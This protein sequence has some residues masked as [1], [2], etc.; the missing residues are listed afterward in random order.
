ML[1]TQNQLSAVYTG[2]RAVYQEG[3]LLT[4]SG[5]EDDWKQI[6]L[7]AP[8]D[9]EQEEYGFMKNMSTI[10]EWVGDRHLQSMVEGSYFIK[11]KPFEGTIAVPATKIADR[12]LGGFSIATKQLGQNARVFPNRLVFPLLAAGF[13]NRGFDGQYFF[14]ANHPV[15]RPDG[16]TDL[17]SNN[18]GGSGAP[19]FLLDTTKIIKPIVFQNRQAFDFVSLTDMSRSDHV[20]MRN[21]YLFGTDGRCN[22][23]YGLWQTAYGSKQALT[24]DNVTA[25]RA[26]MM[27]YKGDN[28]EPIGIVPNLLVVPPALETAAR[29]V[30]DALVVGTDTNVM[31]GVMKTMATAWLA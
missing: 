9:T 29:K 28:G 5:I 22:V 30:T 16:G 8:S 14:D 25:A 1:L 4:G 7:E 27:A 2:L 15:A 3:F 6:A 10:R 11:N 31:K 20:F 26:A 19:W 24:M 23:G 21:E 12:K 13:A 18:G 17:V